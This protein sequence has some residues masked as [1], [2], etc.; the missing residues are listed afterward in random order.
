MKDNIIH[1]SNDVFFKYL[2]CNDTDQ[3]SLFLLKMII[4]RILGISCE[5]V[6]VLNPD[7]IPEQIN[8]KD[9]ILD[10]HVK[11]EDK[12]QI[13][14]EMQTSS[15]SHILSHRLQLYGARMISTQISKGENYKC[16][17][18]VYQ[19]IFL[20]DTN[21]KTNALMDIYTSK[22]QEGIEERFNLITRVYV[23][24]PYI[25]EIVKKKRKLN[26][27]E[28]AIYIF[29]N[30]EDYGRIELDEKVKSIMKKKHERFTED[31]AL[32]WLAFQRQ[33]GQWQHEGE[34][35]ESFEDG[36]NQGY[37]HGHTEG[38]NHGH[39]DG[40]NEGFKQGESEGIK[41]GITKTL[42]LYVQSRFEENIEEELQSLILEQLNVLKEKIYTLETIEEIKETIKNL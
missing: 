8:Q 22:N 20:N 39:E 38:Y 4:H 19:I 2:L 7:L 33:C 5:T 30:G 12:K 21:K 9:L 40:I 3:D 11:T 18:P 14:I 17:N 24:L 25:N 29:K 1:Y 15:F 35:K 42:S 6:R 13:N 37:A 23:Y 16:L 26:D 31:E 27:I 34:I 28:T 36:L 32:S 10:L 41:Q